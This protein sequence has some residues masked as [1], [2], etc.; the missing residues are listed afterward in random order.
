MIRVRT[1]R[2]RLEIAIV[3]ID[4]KQVLNFNLKNLLNLINKILINFILK[5][6]RKPKESI[7]KFKHKFSFLEKILFVIIWCTNL[8]APDHI[9]F[10]IIL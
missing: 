10:A 3:K 8:F 7:V 2:V 4:E 9:L 1:P 6:F 5:Y